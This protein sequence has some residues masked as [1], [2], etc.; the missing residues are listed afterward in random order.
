ML[1]IASAALAVA[2]SVSERDGKAAPSYAADVARI[3]DARCVECHRTGGGAPFALTSYNDAKRKARTIAAVVAS[4][5]MPPWPPTQGAETFRHARRLD[6]ADIA[7]LVAWVDAD[8]PPGDLSNLSPRS[9]SAPIQPLGAPD[10]AMTVG[11]PFHVPASG[12][13]IYRYFALPLNLDATQFLSAIEIRS[14]EPSV[15]H[16]VLFY[17]D[18]SGTAHS[19]ED[20]GGQPGFDGARLNHLRPVGGWAVGMSAQRFPLGLGHP[21]TKGGDLVLQVH[22]HPDGKSRDVALEVALYYC[23]EP[24]ARELLEFQLPPAFGRTYG[25]D[26]PAGDPAYVVHDTW[27]LPADIDLVSVWAHA[28][29]VCVAAEAHATLP[30]GKKVELLTIPRW[31]F[32]WQMRYDFATPV[33]LPKGTVVEG[34]LVYDNSG[35]NPNNPH[36]PPERVTWGEQTTDEMGSLIFNCVAADEADKP[37]LRTSYAAHLAGSSKGALARGAARLLE[38]AKK[39]DANGDRTLDASEI[40]ARFREKLKAFDANGDRK[41]SFEE[42]DVGFGKPASGGA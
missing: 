24:P 12:R 31:N 39:L 13:D 11:R 28:H 33:R 16:H 15:V 17:L 38:G 8:C 6:D 41:V 26:I 37:A 25:I 42:L 35:D 19:R 2:V 30:D 27:T 21:L 34:R 1:L 32:N 23:K 18:G 40:P 5:Q 36:V 29:M 14:S 4:R 22:F 10:L 3:L 9:A 20:Q 7:T